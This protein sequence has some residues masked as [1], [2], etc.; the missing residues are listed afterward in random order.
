MLI[1][2][3]KKTQKGYYIILID[4][5]NASPGKENDPCK[6]VLGEQKS[7]TSSKYM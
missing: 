5:K 3:D 4:I 7:C 2:P 1:L 6:S